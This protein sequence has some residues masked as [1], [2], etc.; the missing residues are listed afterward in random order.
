ML[1]KG[2]N[3]T[4]GVRFTFPT[5]FKG[6]GGEGAS[7]PGAATRSFSGDLL[8]MIAGN[9]RQV[10]R[11]AGSRWH[12]LLVATAR[13]PGCSSAWVNPVPMTTYRALAKYGAE[14]LHSSW[15]S[16]MITVVLTCLSIYLWC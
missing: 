1:S 10:G 5:A 2:S 13:L 8:M 14:L 16:M 12:A 6:E 7:G 3:P 9:C 4:P 15:H 11:L